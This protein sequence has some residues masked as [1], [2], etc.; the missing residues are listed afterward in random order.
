MEVWRLGGGGGGGGAG[1]PTGCRQGGGGGSR[2]T[3]WLRSCV[4]IWAKNSQESLKAPRAELMHGA[5]GRSCSS[6]QA[7]SQVSTVRGVSHYLPLSPLL[8]ARPHW[9]AAPITLVPMYKY[10]PPL[11]PS[12]E[13]STSPVWPIYLTFKPLSKRLCDGRGGE[14]REGGRRR[15]EMYHST[16]P[17][18]LLIKKK[19]KPPQTRVEPSAPGP[20]RVPEETR[21]TTAAEAA[22]VFTWILPPA[23]YS[24]FLTW[25]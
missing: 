1:R 13:I 19:E 16:Y 21:K 12:W 20:T 23:F 6:T 8:V 24:N 14:R 9:A 10:K 22:S 7:V 15:K 25:K 4:F 5:E 11:P 18:I 2:L 3:G 17:E